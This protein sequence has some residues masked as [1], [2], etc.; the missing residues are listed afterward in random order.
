[1]KDA[2]LE[3]EAFLTSTERPKVL[4]R[5]GNLVPSELHHDSACSLAANFDVEE[6]AVLG[7]TNHQ[8]LIDLLLVHVCDELF[9][10]ILSGILLFQRF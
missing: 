5:L 2:V 6:D 3:A 8:R 1:M 7:R 4:H 9:E 10:V